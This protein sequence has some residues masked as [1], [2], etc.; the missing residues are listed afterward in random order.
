[1]AAKQFDKSGNARIACKECEATTGRAKW[2][3]Q[4]AVH[5]ASVH[6]LNV[7]QYKA[8]YPGAPTISEYA[9]K[10]ASVGQKRSKGDTQDSTPTAPKGDTPTDQL[11]F[12]CASLA[13]RNDLSP[14]EQALVP[15][16]DDKFYID[17]QLLEEVA[18]GIEASDNVLIS[19]PTGCGKTTGV[20]ELGAICNQPCL[21]Q[22]LRGD[23]RSSGFVGSKVVEIE[24]DSGKQ[25]TSFRPGIL[26]RAMENGYWLLLDELD[27]APPAILFVLQRVLTHRQL[28]LDDDGGRVVNA[29]PNFRIIA[30]ANTLGRG[31]D[32][33]LYTGTQVLNEAFLDRFGVVVEQNYLG[34]GK[35]G[36]ELATDDAEVQ[37]VSNKAG[38]D[39]DLVKKM[40]TVARLVR[41]GA[42][43]EECYCTFSTRKLLNWAIK[44]VALKGD[45]GRAAKLTF[46]NKLGQDDRTYVRNI[47]NRVLGTSKRY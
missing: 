9:S 40:V 41:Q 39:V 44:T 20:E 32:T 45:W 38:L 34:T 27:A 16:H 23:I 18:L 35:H 36:A 7:E 26:V 29:H 11:Q 14:F 13:I 43:N 8:K 24:E 4:L 42:T 19:G 5:L 22:N 31:D 33:G 10:Q 2:F 37:V 30:T 21:T 15:A 28:I 12:G 47:M 25:V 46:L 1:M 3:H 6:S 17:E